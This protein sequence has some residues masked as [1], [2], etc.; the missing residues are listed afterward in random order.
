MDKETIQALSEGNF[1]EL[2][3][4][5]IHDHYSQPDATYQE[6]QRVFYLFAI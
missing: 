1:V 2:N 3:Q 5:D 6:R 4:N